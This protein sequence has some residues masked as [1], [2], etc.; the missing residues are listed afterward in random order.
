MKANVM[1]QI[2]ALSVAVLPGANAPAG[3]MRPA[4]PTAQTGIQPTPVQGR[5]GR[6]AAPARVPMEARLITGAPYSAEVVIESIQ[7]LLDGNRIVNRTTGRVYRDGQG[8]TRREE[9]REPG[10]VATI[11][12]SDPVAGQSISLDPAS[13]TGWKT[14]ARTASALVERLTATQIEQLLVRE[15]HVAERTVPPPPP[16]PP[17][18]GQ[19]GGGR[20]MIQRAPAPK[21][22]YEERTE[23]LAARNI[24][25]VMAEGTRVTRT[26]P[27][28]AIGNEQPIVTTTEEWISPA[29]NVLVLTRTLDPRT[30]ESTYRLLNVVRGEPNPDWFAIPAD[31]IVRESGVNRVAPLRR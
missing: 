1:L 15:R 30:G 23:K 26:I 22:A 3:Q 27:A 5:G 19:R 28:G 20:G 18:P 6:G 2:V 9:D 13:R 29:L 10:Q 8:R 25:G 12:I 21:P 24:E 16:P 17:A 11:S 4:E 7:T 31:Y 14:P